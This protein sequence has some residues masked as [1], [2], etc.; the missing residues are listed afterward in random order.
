MSEVRRLGAQGLLSPLNPPR[1]DPSP[2]SRYLLGMPYRQAWAICGHRRE[3]GNEGPQ[4]RA[5]KVSGM[6]APGQP[7]TTS[8]ATLGIPRW[9]IHGGELIKFR[10]HQCTSPHLWGWLINS[11][12]ACPIWL[13]A[14][15]GTSSL[16][17]SLRSKV[18]TLQNTSQVHITLSAS[19][20]MICPSLYVTTLRPAGGAF[21]QSSSCLPCLSRAV[22]GCVSLCL[23]RSLALPASVSLSLALTFSTVASCATQNL[24]PHLDNFSSPFLS[25]SNE[26]LSVNFRVKPF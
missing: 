20:T 16:L 23:S 5:W 4:S 11:I 9:L 15:P 25:V 14:I 3:G 17:S 18:S 7:T 6:P 24:F 12:Y 22:S 2:T 19:P 8:M 1:G 21:Y 13:P 26:L 10:D